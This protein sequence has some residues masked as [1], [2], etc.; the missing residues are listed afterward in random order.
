MIHKLTIQN[1]IKLE[2]PYHC[3]ILRASTCR[4]RPGTI[5]LLSYP[6]VHQTLSYPLFCPLPALKGVQGRVF[7][8]LEFVWVICTFNLELFPSTSWL[9]TW[10]FKLRSQR[11]WRKKVNFRSASWMTP[12]SVMTWLTRTI[13]EFLDLWWQGLLSNLNVGI[14]TIQTVIQ[15]AYTIEQNDCETCSLIY[16]I[17]LYSL[18]SVLTVCQGYFSQLRW[19]FFLIVVGCCCYAHVKLAVLKLILL[20]WSL[21]SFN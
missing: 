20:G 13:S 6:F 12:S 17:F 10:A 8:S 1:V 14:I 19:S 9:S 5:N 15:M 21:T 11:G 4:S 16:W 2:L 3:M 18:L 7:M